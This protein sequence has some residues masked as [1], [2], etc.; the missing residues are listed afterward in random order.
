MR[1]LGVVS[2]SELLSRGADLEDLINFQ[3]LE[4]IEPSVDTQMARYFTRLAADLDEIRM[5]LQALLNP[6]SNPKPSFKTQK[7]IYPSVLDQVLY[8]ENKD[9][10]EENALQRIREEVAR[11]AKTVFFKDGK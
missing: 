1:S 10:V 9:Q 3:A 11:K 8:A 5:L 4:L 2:L 6:K 7:D